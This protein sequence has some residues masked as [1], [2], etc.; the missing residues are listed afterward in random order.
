MPRRTAAHRTAQRTGATEER[1]AMACAASE[2]RGRGEVAK[3][4]CASEVLRGFLSI[5][6]KVCPLKNQKQM[7]SSIA[8]RVQMLSLINFRTFS[9]MLLGVL[10]AHVLHH[11]LLCRQLILLHNPFLVLIREALQ[12]EHNFSFDSPCLSKSFR[13]R[14]WTTCSCSGSTASSP[15]AG[16]CDRRC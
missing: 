7:V 3:A 2:E 4:R 9:V 10:P 5:G 11:E 8:P 1:G 16:S 14:P 15:P 12:L 6:H 13:R